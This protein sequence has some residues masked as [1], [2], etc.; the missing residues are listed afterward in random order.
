MDPIEG[1]IS[2]DALADQI[3]EGLGEDLD[4]EREAP[5]P[6][7]P[8]ADDQVDDATEESD[9]SD[10]Q[11]D[12]EAEEGD[13]EEGDGEEDAPNPTIDDETLV[14]IKIGEDEYEVNFAELRAGYLR[15]E[16]FMARSQKL[17][18]DHQAKIEEL[19]AD[20]DALLQELT[21]AS[22]IVKSDTSKFDN[23]DWA[24]LK[25]QDP[26][27]YARLRVQA[28][29]A[30]EQAQALETRR[31]NIAAIQQK[32]RELKFKAYAEQQ[33]TMAAK[34]I[35]D[36]DKEETKV[37]LAK[38]AQDIGYTPEEIYGIVDARHLLLLHTA[39]QHSQSAVRRKEAAE[40]KVTKGLPPVNKSGASVPQNHAD[41]AASKAKLA[42]FKQDKSVESAAALLAASFD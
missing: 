9:D 25:Q 18:A 35:P 8:D 3:A 29:E 28:L 37:A 5:A 11:E 17:E 41:R 31:Q 6:A 27:Q 23:V 24:T 42:R 40:K 10:E 26:D 22:T 1:A 14:D 33:L 38:Y 13:E 2:L 20:R 36:F 15:N 16:D 21:V 39:L 32:T 12:D 30:K 19:E 34:L 7:D 4:Y